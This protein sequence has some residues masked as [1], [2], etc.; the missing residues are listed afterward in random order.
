MM[1]S[2]ASNGLEANSI[3]NKRAAA[4]TSVNEGTPKSGEQK[5]SSKSGKPSTPQPEPALSASGAGERISNLPN[6]G[7]GGNGS[8][9]SG[10][11]I[12][13]GNATVGSNNGNT[14]A[15]GNVKKEKRVP[16][17]GT[18]TVSNISSGFA[19]NSTAVNTGK[20]TSSKNSGNES[21]I[22]AQAY[23]P[24]KSSPDDLPIDPNEPRY[25]ICDGVSWGDMIGC[26]NQDVR[27]KFGHVFNFL[28][29]V[30]VIQSA[31]LNGSTMHA[32]AYQKS[33]LQSPSAAAASEDSPGLSPFQSS[34]RLSLSLRLPLP[35]RPTFSAPLVQ[36]AHGAELIAYAFGFLASDPASF[37]TIRGVCRSSLQFV[38][39]NP[40]L[41]AQ[42]LILRQVILS[43]SCKHLVLHYVAFNIPY[44]LTPAV[45]FALNSQ[46]A[47][48]QKYLI[49]RLLSENLKD[50]AGA[51]SF[52]PQESIDHIV[53]LGFKL[54][55]DALVVPSSNKD[56]H[57]TD[58]ATLF[59]T[60]LNS[61][62]PDLNALRT[63][64]A[65]HHFTP[66]L[67]DPS[68]DFW[69]TFW[70]DIRRLVSLDLDMGIHI[71]KHSGLRFQDAKDRMMSEALRD[72]HA[73]TTSVDVLTNL[74]FTITESVA[75]SILSHAG[76]FDSPVNNQGIPTSV[77]L[78][79][80]FLDVSQLH[81]SVLLTLSVLFKTDPSTVG[82]SSV[83]SQQCD[84]LLRLFK[85]QLTTIQ[86]AQ[87]ILASPQSSTV[88]HKRTL[89]FMT[90]FGQTHGGMVD[91]IWQVI[92]AEFG[93]THSFV[94]AFL[95][96]TVIGGTITSTS[97]LSGRGVEGGV[98]MKRQS[99]VYSVASRRP[100]LTPLA[101]D[102]QGRTSMDETIAVVVRNGVIRKQSI[103]LQKQN[104]VSNAS[105][106]PMNGRSLSKSGR[107][108]TSDSRL[109][110][111]MSASGSGAA[112]VWAED[113]TE[114]ADE[115]SGSND[116]E[117]AQRDAV[118][119][120]SINAMFG[121]GVPLDPG[122]LIPICRAVLILGSVKSRFIDFMARVE[123]S[124]IAAAFSP[125]TVDL[126]PNLSRTQWINALCR[127]VL[128][129]QAWIDHVMTNS[130]LTALE[131]LKPPQQPH[132][133]RKRANT[134][135]APVRGI[136]G[137]PMY[138]EIIEAGG[139]A[140][141]VEM[142]SGPI[143]VSV[144]AV[145]RSVRMRRQKSVG[146]RS[147]AATVR[148]AS[149]AVAATAVVDAADM[150][151][152]FRCCEELVSILENAERGAG[153]D[154]IGGAA[155]FGR[156]LAEKDSV[157][158]GWNGWLKRGLGF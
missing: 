131:G 141:V 56:N 111:S 4:S 11:Q 68:D 94:A 74:G 23:N 116:S 39:V 53:A 31:K 27:M 8:A 29:T 93:T 35:N 134:V 150:K 81:N 140:S 14:A 90:L 20:K 149:G 106:A 147:G 10:A 33:T 52:I 97:A 146:S 46:G 28:L 112:P 72:S 19:A 24:G 76:D 18:G 44:A 70:K 25:C 42:Y 26:D 78:L 135:H 158:Y 104:A 60:L 80:A 143:P 65:A 126:P 102:A 22:E 110:S 157:V 34:P 101:V 139:A 54:F 6:G 114:D 48:L 16:A 88:K 5:Q 99:S 125:V 152:F 154:A 155:P 128:E 118:G 136:F 57:P 61:G 43:A 40:L 62:D 63:I 1:T 12:S 82:G 151:R 30:S 132:H 92:C 121:L 103:T 122:M 13:S 47:V 84:A 120:E 21:K 32:W 98:S 153:H 73:T 156:W 86:L 124:V 144:Q 145:A 89:P 138:A 83:V 129:S 41:R 109:G 2:A 119:R 9:W 38:N 130:E 69:L 115:S 3:S 127:T 58:D 117:D 95:V 51:V 7:A 87:A 85:G 105:P 37:E 71:L 15:G 66:A 91:S 113:E 79:Q 142:D 75:V 55:G 137:D 45:F 123:K 17:G 67:V 36:F 108:W 100:S 77:A 96:D 59:H 133:G 64:I 148:R 49:E 50:S 107:S